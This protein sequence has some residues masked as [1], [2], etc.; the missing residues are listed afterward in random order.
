MA[1]LCPK[2]EFLYYQ[3][4]FRIISLFELITNH[5]KVFQKV[6]LPSRF[7]NASGGVKDGNDGNTLFIPLNLPSDTG[8]ILSKR[9]NEI[10]ERDET[11]KKSDEDKKITDRDGE[12]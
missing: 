3:V 11:R 8:R 5:L 10:P 1:D 7:I 4:I 12:I 2:R 9:D 6:P